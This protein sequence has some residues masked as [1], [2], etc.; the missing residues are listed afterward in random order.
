MT[1][2]TIFLDFSA[3]SMLRDGPKY[4]RIRVKD[5]YWKYNYFINDQDSF[6]YIITTLMLATFFVAE[7]VNMLMTIV[8]H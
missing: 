8:N 5:S 6:K 3:E 4:S 2:Q 1:S 7:K